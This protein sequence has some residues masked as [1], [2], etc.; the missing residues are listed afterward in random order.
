MALKISDFDG[1]VV[2]PGGD[3]P[4]GD[5]KN[6]PSGTR[7]NRKMLDDMIQFF[8]KAMDLAGI[9]PNSLP[10]NVTNGYQ[11]IDAVFGFNGSGSVAVSTVAGSGGVT[12]TIDYV[13]NTTSNTLQLRGALVAANAQNFVATPALNSYTMQTLPVGFRPANTCYFLAYAADGTGVRILDDTTTQFI[14]SI[15]I[16]VASTGTIVARW[17]KPNPGTA[18]YF[19]DFNAVIPLY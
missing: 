3:Y 7:A 2:A 12:G 4:F 1:T 14:D 13:R 9:T 17:I 18:A 8:Q 15:I 5:I 11:L 19:I 6:I 10:D 16:T